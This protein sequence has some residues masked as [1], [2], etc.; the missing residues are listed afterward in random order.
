[1]SELSKIERGFYHLTPNGWARRDHQ[2][3]PKDRVETWAYEMECPAEDAKERVRLTR[4]GT[5]GNRNT[6]AQRPA[7]PV[8]RTD[9]ADTRTE[10][11]AG[12]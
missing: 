3:F 10:Y 5:T 8:R 7:L 6:G 4:M 11:H 12:M 9:G 2:P 1:M